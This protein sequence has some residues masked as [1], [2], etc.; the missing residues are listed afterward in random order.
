MTTSDKIKA[1]YAARKKKYL[2]RDLYDECSVLWE[3]Y[4]TH[5]SRLAGRR[6]QDAIQAKNANEARREARKAAAHAARAL[7]CRERQAAEEA[8][9]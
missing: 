9:R 2:P 7:K 5:E 3:D 1:F 4:Y 8:A 6:A